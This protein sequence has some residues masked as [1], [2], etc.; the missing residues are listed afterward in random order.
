MTTWEQKMR[1][2]ILQ[3]AHYEG[4]LVED[5]WK[6]AVQNHFTDGRDSWEITLGAR[7]ENGHILEFR[8][9]K[10]VGTEWMYWA[11]DEETG[12]WNWTFGGTEPTFVDSD[13]EGHD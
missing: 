2:D 7:F 10:L 1:K 11:E 8:G 3:N 5:W 13:Y 9:D 12:F 6:R 4:V